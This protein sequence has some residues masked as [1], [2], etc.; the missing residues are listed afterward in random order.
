[1]RKLAVSALLAA[2][3]LVAP[4]CAESDPN[5]FETHVEKLKE[6]S[7]RATGMSGLQ[8][9]VKTIVTARN[10]ERIA[11][12]GDKV[13]PAFLEI[14]DEAPEQREAMLKILL[15]VGDAKATPVWVKALALDGSAEARTAALLALE[16][17]KKAKPADAVEPLI[18]ALDAL[19]ADPKN[20]KGNEEGKVRLEL[21]EVL[22]AVRDKRAV[23]VLIKALEQTKEN[24]PV[25]IH[26][27]AA[28]ALGEIG[29]PAAVDALLTVQF[30]VPDAPSTTDISNRAKLALV[31]IGDPAVP[32]VMK[33][34]RG[35]MEAVNKLAADAGVDIGVVKQSAAGI[36]TSMGT[37]AAVE[38]LVA[39]MP[40]ADCEEGVDPDEVDPADANLRAFV[41]RA[42][43][44]IGDDRAVEALCTCSLASKNPGD[45]FEIAN[46]LGRIGGPKAAECLN[47]V[48]ATGE[49]DQE[50]VTNSDFVHQIRW[51]AA[52]FAV[53][54]ADGAT[55]A[56]VKEA[57]AAGAKG[58]AKVAEELKAWEPGVALVE[59]CKDDKACYLESV[60]DTTADW[61]PREVAASAL[62]RLA[63]GDAAVAEE[64]AKAFKVR[65]PDARVTMAWATWK[66]MDGAK[67][68]PCA[69]ALQAVIDGEKGSMPPTMQ[70]AVLTAR[71]SIA[72]LAAPA[73]AAAAA[74]PA[75][76]A[77]AADAKPADAK[78]ADDAKP[79]E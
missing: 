60:K 52:R 39:F 8:K 42:L 50:A 17:M 77:P 12:F 34:L 69:D 10:A 49:Y 63:K 75:A 76:D 67:C 24:Q 65:S 44:F 25:A 62:V 15:D 1:M 16:G 23:P 61:F 18:A 26:R 28:S 37:K 66:L 38:D 64:V 48:V 2:L 78:P 45:M 79:A 5:K 68:Q 57:M 54:A 6:Q 13:V 32:G 7:S 47:K 56:A 27:A 33:M 19:I 43:G 70:L 55:I 73:A 22:G 46:A 41:A 74:A 29:D 4:A 58:D 53:L 51:E 14:W 72:K 31:A 3:F 11:E 21:V 35:E 9:L 71:D 59:K 30:R 20:D 36:L 40:K